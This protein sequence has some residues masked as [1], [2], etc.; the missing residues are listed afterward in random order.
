MKLIVSYPTNEKSNVTEHT[1]QVVEREVEIDVKKIY[2]HPSQWNGKA[3]NRYHYSAIIPAPDDLADW[4]KLGGFVRCNIDRKQNQHFKP[5]KM[6]F[7]GSYWI[8]E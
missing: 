1:Y 2:R 4:M 8:Q 6:K 3:K 5:T 7:D